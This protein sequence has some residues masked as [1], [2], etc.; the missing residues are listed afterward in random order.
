MWARIKAIIRREYLER[1]RTKAFWISTLVVPFFLGAVMILPAYLAARGGG[2]FSVAVIDLSG[3]FFD[4]VQTEVDR[5]LEGDDEKLSIALHQQDP[6]ADPEATRERI[7]DRVQHKEF[8]GMLVIPAEMPDEG[9]PEYVAPNVA[10]FKL[11]TVL[12]RSVNNVMVAD[13]LTGA[14]LDPE[15]VRELTKRVGL[16]TMKLGKGGEE[17]RDRGQ[18]FII[19]YVFMMIIYITV[20]MYGIYVMRGVLE[21][22]SSHVVEVVISTV[23]PFELMLGK[24]LGIGAVGLTQFLIWAV[25]MAAISA[26]GAMSAVGI[27]GMELPTVPAQVLFFFVVYFVLGFLLYGT[28]YAGIGAAFDTEQEAQNFQGL[29]TMFLV[30]PLVLMMQI[31][32]Q[33]D[34]TLSVVLSLIPFFTPMLMF[35]RITLTPVPAIQLVA[36]VVLMIGAILACTWVVAKIY[37]VGILMHGS[38]PKLKDLIRWVREA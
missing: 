19:A 4:P 30:V 8:D 11:L 32:N 34:G 21:E 1:V 12:E 3:R 29:I 9:Q 35:L 13:R 14:G 23:K 5:M 25:L 10:A 31:L 26:P 28:L 18:S 36:S 27:S 16:K 33:P 38:K 22:K 17:T 20:L 15:K 24:I 2:E 7:K 37:R 6:G